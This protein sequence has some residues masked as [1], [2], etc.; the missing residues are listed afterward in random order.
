MPVGSADIPK[1]PAANTAPAMLRLSHSIA[2]ALSIRNL[3]PAN[4]L[5]LPGA[6]LV[7]MQAQLF[8]SFVFVN[9]GFPSFFQ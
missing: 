9:L 2:A 4:A 6:L 3:R 7:T 1:K 5:L 8:A